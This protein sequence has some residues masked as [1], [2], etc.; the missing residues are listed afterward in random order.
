MSSFEATRWVRLT[1]PWQDDAVR[2][3]CQELTALQSVTDIK[4]IPEKCSLRIQ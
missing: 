4:L 2:D 3:T 1:K